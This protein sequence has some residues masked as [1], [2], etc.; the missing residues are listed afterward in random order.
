VRKVKVILGL[1]LFAL[2]AS[3]VWQLVACEIANAEFK[4]ELKDVASLSGARIGLAAQQT[5]DDLRASVIRKAASHDIRM[6]PQQILIRRSGS[7]EDPH[8]YL[9]AKYRE[10][11]WVPGVAL[12][13]HFTAASE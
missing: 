3:V 10:R 4:D 13:L 6:T 12:V 5:D 8:I 7:E 1:L 2:I 9:M 11:I